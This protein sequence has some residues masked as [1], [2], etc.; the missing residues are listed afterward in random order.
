[1]VCVVLL[2]VSVW[3]PFFSFFD[4]RSNLAALYIQDNISYQL[5]SVC[6]SSTGSDYLALG[7][8]FH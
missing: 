5:F 3:S 1:M 8:L 6:F 7:S 4:S 2:E